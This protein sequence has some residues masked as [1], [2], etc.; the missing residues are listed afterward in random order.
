MLRR[1]DVLKSVS[2]LSLA[3]VLASPALTKAAAASTK[4]LTLR[5]AGGREVGGA[6]ALPDPA[7]GPAPSVVLVHEWWGLNDHIKAVAA[8]FAKLG[9]AAL[10]V[11]LMGG[12]VA[13]TPEKARQQMQAV[14]GAEA[15]DTMVSWIDWMRRHEATT[16]KVATIGWCFGGGWSLNASIAAP[17]D[18]TVIY[19]GNVAK[20]S[21]H[22]AKLNGPVIGHF[23]TKDKWINKPMVDG[24]VAN[25][26]EAGKA[27]TVYWYEA[28]HAFANPTSARYDN[29]DAAL[30]W[31]RTQSF[32]TQTLKSG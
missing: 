18:G 28:D 5:T 17:V 32:L 26:A 23:A 4:T 10:A 25:M 2:T 9:Y 21:D 20:P 30:S 8:D 27:L 11:D 14:V 7:A 1:R 3:A 24:F 15:E 6:L 12:E 13:T 31:E 19:Y 22:L 16:D 29:Q